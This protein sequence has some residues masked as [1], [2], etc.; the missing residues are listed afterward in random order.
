MLSQGAHTHTR[1][2]TLTHPQRGSII[3]NRPGLGQREDVSSIFP[4]Q[5]REQRSVLWRSQQKEFPW[6]QQ[7]FYSTHFYF[8][9]VLPSHKASFFYF[10]SLPHFS[11]VVTRIPWQFCS[12]LVWQLCDITD[13]CDD[14][15]SHT[16]LFQCRYYRHSCWKPD[17]I[18]VWVSHTT[19]FIFIARGLRCV[20]KRSSARLSW[21]HPQHVD[22]QDI[23][24]STFNSVRKA[25]QKTSMPIWE[26]TSIQIRHMCTNV[27][28]DLHSSV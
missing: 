28:T 3:S 14:H 1:A 12:S 16:P 25:K 24:W 11:C 23:W 9:A 26:L 8:F 20:D 2:N 19:T 21:T 15:P 10:T 13:C 5:R 22:Y 7:C 18:T 27:G 6:T 17:Y 4:L